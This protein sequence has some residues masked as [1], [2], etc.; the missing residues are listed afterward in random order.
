LLVALILV[1][2]KGFELLKDGSPSE[3]NR[4]AYLDVGQAPTLHP[5][6]DGADR[7]VKPPCDFGFMEKS[8]VSRQSSRLTL[9]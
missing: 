4:A 3:Q 5:G 8:F 7:F 2:P 6:V 9:R 1:D